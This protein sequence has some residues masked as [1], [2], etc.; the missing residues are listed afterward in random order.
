MGTRTLSLHSTHTKHQTLAPYPYIAPSTKPPYPLLNTLPLTR[1][2]KNAWKCC[3][4]RIFALRKACEKLA[5]RIAK[6]IKALK[7]K[8]FVKFFSL[9][10]FCEKYPTQT[11]TYRLT[12]QS[13]GTIFA[14]KKLVFSI[15]FCFTE[16]LKKWKTKTK[17]NI[18]R[19]AF[20]SISLFFSQAFRI[21]FAK[22][23]FSKNY[24]IPK[25]RHP[26]YPLLSTLPLTHPP[27]PFS[28][29]K[30]IVAQALA[31]CL[32]NRWKSRV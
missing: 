9:F 20:A 5:K 22:L 31:W 18:E 1:P 28:M 16:K 25:H 30:S 19:V 26:P 10:Q 24:V 13:V 3:G 2:P 21:L 32:V 6:C 17:Q 27:A 4:T 12:S 8:H 14:G 7:I 29:L 11:T 15:Y 23:H